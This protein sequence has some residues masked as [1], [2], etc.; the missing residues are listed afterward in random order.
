MDGG[1]DEKVEGG[2]ERSDN[3]EGATR[4]VDCVLD[5][6]RGLSACL[7]YTGSSMEVCTEPVCMVNRLLSR[8]RLSPE[9]AC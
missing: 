1:G 8:P 5:I 6:V 9:L 7:T 4:K 3:K 2:R